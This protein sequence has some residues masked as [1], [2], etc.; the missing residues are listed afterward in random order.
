MQ[1]F[2]VNESKGWGIRT[3]ESLRRGS[4]LFEYAGEVITNAELLRRGDRTKYSVALD[5]DW[6]SESQKD[7]DSLLCIDATD[8]TNV[9]RW[10][11]HK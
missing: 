2:Y 7:D 3:T 10:L 5:A 6:E 9:T 1:V 11:N 4:F 8:I